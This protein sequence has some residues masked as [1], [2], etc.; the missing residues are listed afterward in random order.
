MNLVAYK[1]FI[2]WWVSVLLIG[3]SLFWAAYFGTIE[4]IW[5]NDPTKIT[6]VILFLFLTTN[7]VL[8]WL[9][10]K[11][12]NPIFMSANKTLLKK[13][14]D[15]SWFMS[16]I[17]LAIG[18]FGTVLG[19]IHMLQVTGAGDIKEGGAQ[20]ADFVMKLLQAMGFALY[21]NAVGLMFSI[22]LKVQVYFVG[23]E[24]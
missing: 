1:R 5:N 9:A 7:A 20:I 19:L 8:G 24:E 16:E 14:T 15:Y 18:M 6:T 11:A 12:S 22:I 3:T 21:T 17:L 10:W 13:I 4:T 23:V 2:I